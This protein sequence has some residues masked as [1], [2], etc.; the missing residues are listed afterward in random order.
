M[1][2]QAAALAGLGVQRDGRGRA[3][4]AMVSSLAC[5]LP[6]LSA[7]V[8]GQLSWAVSHWAGGAGA[9]C[10]RPARRAVGPVLSARGWCRAAPGSSSF[11]CS[12]LSSPRA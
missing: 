10:L 2:G 9:G 1:A 6:N 11:M 3:V 7:P 12:P 8:P 4:S 5:A